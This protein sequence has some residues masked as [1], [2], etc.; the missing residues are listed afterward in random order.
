MGAAWQNALHKK[1]NMQ[2]IHVCRVDDLR[3][4]AAYVKKSGKNNSFPAK[5]M[6]GELP[7]S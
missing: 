7:H 5:D 3:K 1:P 2:E 6:H 4:A